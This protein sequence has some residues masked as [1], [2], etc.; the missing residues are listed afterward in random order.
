[1]PDR[2]HAAR[3]RTRW[4]IAA[5][6]GVAAVA[7]FLYFRAGSG[8]EGGGAAEE[9]DPPTIVDIGVA[10]RRD[11]PIEATAVGT[12]E[13]ENS[14]LVR[15]RVDGRIVAVR[16]SEGQQVEAGQ[17][18][19]EIDP[20]PLRAELDHAR[21]MHANALER[22]ANARRELGRMASLAERKLVA[23]QAF[24]AARSQVDQLE[25][26]AAAVEAPLSPDGFAPD[27][28]GVQGGPSSD[29]RA[30]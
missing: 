14:V 6:A 16:F 17:V 2:M 22:L 24:D 11:F 19:F 29:A 8:S 1:M 27:I 12:V 28:S 25:D 5:L 9:E 20:R 10:Q 30:D 21:A 15:S 3:R 7:A 4:I 13:A 26:E 18:L 23:A